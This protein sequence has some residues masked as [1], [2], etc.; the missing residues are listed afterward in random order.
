METIDPMAWGIKGLVRV[1]DPDTSR[2]AAEC[3]IPN[4]TKLQALVYET[5]K[6][7]GPVTDEKLENCFDRNAFG[8]T[9]IRKRR[10]ELYQAGVLR[11]VGRAT[12]ARGRSMILWDIVR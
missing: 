1:V 8:P 11:D 4:L 7:H 6:L 10:T 12:N 5:I 3:L 2:L 9:T